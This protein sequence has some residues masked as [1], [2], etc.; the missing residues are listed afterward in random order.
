MSAQPRTSFRSGFSVFD[1]PHADPRHARNPAG[2][3]RRSILAQ[4]D[5]SR[6]NAASTDDAGADEILH[7]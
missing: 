1:A 2:T 3:F 5:R 6:H 7:V 4:F